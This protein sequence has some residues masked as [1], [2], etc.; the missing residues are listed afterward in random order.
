MIQEI[1]TYIIVGIAVIYL[2]R[3]F[4]FSNDKDGCDTNCNC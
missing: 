1:V 4:F 3:K 2:I